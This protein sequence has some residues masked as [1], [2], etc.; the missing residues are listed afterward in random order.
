MSGQSQ[1]EWCMD[2]IP[3]QA[4]TGPNP[5]DTQDFPARRKGETANRAGLPRTACPHAMGTRARIDWLAGW[6]AE[7]N[8]VESDT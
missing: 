5:D 4:L 8:G 7:N 2:K 6:W 3:W 1:V